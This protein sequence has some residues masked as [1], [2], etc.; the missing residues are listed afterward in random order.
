MESKN[1]G[2][3]EGELEDD[4][5][6]TKKCPERAY[7]YWVTKEQGSFEWF[8]GVMDYITKHD[9]NKEMQNLQLLPWC[10]LYNMLGMELM[11]YHRIR[12]SP[13]AKGGY[14]GLLKI[15]QKVGVQEIKSKG[16]RPKPTPSKNPRSA[17]KEC[18]EKGIEGV[19]KYCATSLESMIDF[20]M[21]KLGKKVNAISTEVEKER[22]V[23]VLSKG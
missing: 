18:E 7:F 3:A 16:K 11:S 19:E 22:E 6:G 2:G 21:S 10:S 23:Y 8:K 4:G 9:K 14:M 5:Q 1:F 17:P 13:L 12:D 15:F 20:S